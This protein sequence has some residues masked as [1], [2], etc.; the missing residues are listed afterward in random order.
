MQIRRS[1]REIKVM[2][3]WRFEELNDADF[4]FKEGT[5]ES[6]LDKLA[7]KLEKSRS[8]LDILFAELQKC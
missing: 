1:W 3:K 2:L 7:S 5:K 4:E 6:M 8:E